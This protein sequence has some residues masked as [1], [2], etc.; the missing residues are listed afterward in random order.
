MTD[1]DT[2]AYIAGLVSGALLMAVVVTGT[3]LA[4]GV[5]IIRHTY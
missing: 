4:W 5:W 3:M 1:R 2:L